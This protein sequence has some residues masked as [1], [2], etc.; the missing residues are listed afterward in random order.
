M[1][2]LAAAE[3]TPKRKVRLCLFNPFH[4]LAGGKALA[5][6]IVLILTTGA[7]ACLSNSRLDG[8][9]DFHTTFQPLSPAWLPV[10]DGLLAWIIMGVLLL[11]GGKI[12]STSRFRALDVF[13]TQAL[14]RFPHLFTAA[15]ALLPGA[16]RYAQN[17]QVNYLAS[18]GP[19]QVSTADAYLFMT[20][21]LLSILMTAWMIALMYRAFAVSCNVKGGKAIGVFTAAI[22]LGE[23][24]SKVALFNLQKALPL[25]Y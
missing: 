11:A 19:V 9:I 3:K 17:L 18:G 22:I 5:L 12:I 13:G 7:V 4:Y 1:D 2:E 21:M 25:F 10:S 8:V 24:L 20:V 14:A 16:Q 15:F 23:V 6:G